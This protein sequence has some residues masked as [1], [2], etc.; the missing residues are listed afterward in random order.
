[1]YILLFYHFAESKPCD[2]N[3]CSVGVCS[4]GTNSLFT[5]DCSGTL[6]RGLQ[7]EIGTVK[8][9]PLPITAGS[10]F[11]IMYRSTPSK[12]ITV[13]LN[14]SETY[15]KGRNTVTITAPENT[16]NSDISVIT[17]QT[18]G[19]FTIKHTLQGEDLNEIVYDKPEDS[20][21]LITDSITPYTDYFTANK[22]QPPYLSSGCCW[23]QYHFQSSTPSCLD[24]ITFTSSC[25]WIDSTSIVGTNGIV[26]LWK[27]SD[28]HLPVSIGGLSHDSSSSKFNM[29]G[30]SNKPQ[31]SVCVSC[32]NCTSNCATSNNYYSVNTQDI[33]L[34]LNKRSLLS[35]FFDKV[36]SFLPSWL[37]LHIPE[38]T[39]AIGFHL[40]DY[41]AFIGSATDAAKLYG[42]DNIP[43]SQTN[44][45]YIIR[46]STNLT[47]VI[48]SSYPN[49]P[50]NYFN[51][52]TKD[53]D[54]SPIC[55]ALD[56]CAGHS[57]KLHIGIPESLAE[58][59]SS[60]P[61]FQDF[62]SK[63]WTLDYQYLSLAEF[64]F[65]VDLTDHALWNGSHYSHITSNETSYDFQISFDRLHGSLTGG[66]LNGSL[67]FSGLLMHQRAMGSRY[68]VCYINLDDT[69]FITINL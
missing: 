8:V 60:F 11:T 3:P 13:V 37:T 48:A 14:F 16:S 45:I 52:T 62:V 10:Q 6:R 9:E 65:P 24:H 23:Y 41:S 18:S 21:V 53:S 26:F 43:L 66:Y 63:G 51:Y 22:L 20:V 59:I 15:L 28:L 46:S 36:V 19:L 42:C 69:V 40:Y 1:M 68:Q 4:P 30:F 32:P 57:S 44:L 56:V 50:P 12:S 55:Y 34:M 38:V 35:T 61:S 31:C 47:V 39:Q 67:D 2:P 7:C 29:A 17:D 54:S 33:Q 25:S 58:F 64:G 5:C 49:N 27:D